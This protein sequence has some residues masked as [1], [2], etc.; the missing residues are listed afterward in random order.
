[1]RDNGV[2]ISPEMLTHVFDLF[3]QAEW[4]AD[5]SEGGLGIG[6]TL[7]KRLV[8]LHG[9]RI[10]AHSAGKGQ[11]SEFVLY[12]PLCP[13]GALSNQ[14]PET[15]LPEAGSRHILV[16]EDNE[17]GRESLEALLK[18]LGHRVVAAVDGSQGIALAL[19]ARPEVALI[20]IG[21]PGL[22]G[23]QVAEQIR[24]ALGQTIRLVAMTGFGQ[25]DDRR[26]AREAGFDA[27]LVKPV[28][29]DALQ[30][31]LMSATAS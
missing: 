18:L 15:K 2:G 16:I 17:D 8:E 29:V 24:A 10:S 12:L 19:Q 30:Q 1:V 20:D 3:T 22:D 25:P 28:E 27:H 4:S 13:E 6:L 26:R 14:V 21:L 5:R 23:F 31:I 9:G 7:V 11:G